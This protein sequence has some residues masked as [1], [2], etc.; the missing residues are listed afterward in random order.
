MRVYARDLPCVVRHQE[1]EAVHLFA[2]GRRRRRLAGRLAPL[3]KLE[4]LIRLEGSRLG[5]T[6]RFGGTGDAASVSEKF[7]IRSGP[8]E[9]SGAS[10]S[11]AVASVAGIM[12]S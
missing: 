5:K 7:G 6:G 1:L 11:E 9:L 2:L 4:E 10:E 3:R 12:T 8:I